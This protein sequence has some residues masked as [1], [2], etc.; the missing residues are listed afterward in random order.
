MGIR[1]ALMQQGR[2][3][4]GGALNQGILICP[5]NF[6]FNWT[7]FLLLLAESGFIRDDNGSQ[8]ERM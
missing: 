1:G 4:R 2:K 6:N 8:K 7:D 5:H 3:E